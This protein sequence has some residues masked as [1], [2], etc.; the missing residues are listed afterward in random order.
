[1]YLLKISRGKESLVGSVFAKYGFDVKTTAERGLL[2][3]AKRPSSDLMEKFETYIQ[4]IIEVKEDE[5][6][7][8]LNGNGKEGS[9][10]EKIKEMV[11]VEVISGAY[12]GFRGIVRKVKNEMVFVDLNLFGKATMVELS[13]SEIKVLPSDPWA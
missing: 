2:V 1:M 5:V 7:K 13:E 3:C 11:P 9:G 8:L 10:E 6:G 12:E 4:E